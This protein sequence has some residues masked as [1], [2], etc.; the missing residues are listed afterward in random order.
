MKNIFLIL[1]TAVTVSLDSFV[2]GFSLS[3]NKRSD[4][5]LPAAVAL[6]TLLLCL[7]TTLL[8]KYLF[9]HAE[10]YVNWVGAAL[11]LLLAVIDLFDGQ[12]NNVQLGEV[13]LF[14]SLTIGI[15]VGM[16]AAIANLSL[17]LD[18]VGLAAPIIFT[19]MHYFAVWLGQ[20][21]ANKIALEHTNVLS[22]VILATL[23]LLKLL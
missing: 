9:A 11:L 1:I 17:T 19:V 13:T 18:G 14:E 8:G 7:A 22:A 16:D 15:A 20:K 5:M 21:L 6:M 23:A 10:Q 2:A 3:L 12:C 4:T